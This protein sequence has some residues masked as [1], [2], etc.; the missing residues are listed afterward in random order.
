M[1]NRLAA[2]N[3]FDATVR[4]NNK[5]SGQKQTVTFRKSKQRCPEFH[6]LPPLLGTQHKQCYGNTTYCAEEGDDAA[7]I[8]VGDNKKT[9]V[10]FVRAAF[11][12]FYGSFRGDG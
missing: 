7:V 8:V 6:P 11:V 5:N 2:E 3:R 9:A 10:T 1:R 4:K 12:G